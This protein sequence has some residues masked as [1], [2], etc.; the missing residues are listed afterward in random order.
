VKR[1]LVLLAAA[2]VLLSAACGAVTPFAAIVNGDRVNQRDLD[3]ELNAL[4]SNK[5]FVESLQAQGATVEGT[6]KGTFDMAFVA[7]VLTRRIFFTLIHQEVERRKLEITDADVTRARR[8]A[9]QDFGGEEAMKDFPKSYIDEATRTTADINALREDMG[10]G[11]ATPEKIKA[12]Y[13]AHMADFQETCLSHI[14]VE[15]EPKAND[16]KAQLDG[17]ADFA[18]LA[19]KESKDNQGPAGGS[20]AK[21]GSLDCITTAD[22]AGFVPEFVAGYKDLAVGAT[23]GPV[24]T[25]FGLHLIRVTERKQQSLE[26]ATAA[27]T[28][29]LGG[30]VDQ[31]F[32][33]LVLAT[34]RKAKIRVNP[35]YGTFDPDQL[36]VVPPTAPPA[37]GP[38]TSGLPFAPAPGG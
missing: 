16:I 33:D 10:K 27:I 38:P 28:Q 5:A 12:Y 8:E 32:N 15:D 17:G 36:T 29:Q 11:E 2:A 37:A 1:L 3:D 23:S 6:S 20:A 26:D 31:Q 25:Q 13:D 7:R 4:K 14:L 9:Q 18:E 22:S 21:G 34:A 24:K 35:K 19:K 30:D